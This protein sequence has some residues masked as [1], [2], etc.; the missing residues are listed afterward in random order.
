MSSDVGYKYTTDF[1]GLNSI[2]YVEL[3]LILRNPKMKVWRIIYMQK[4][5][6]LLTFF[7]AF[8]S[9]S[10]F[11]KADDKGLPSKWEGIWKGMTTLTWSSGK[12]E[13][14]ET[15]IQ[16]AAI[17]KSKAKQ[18]KIIYKFSDRTEERNYE[19]KPV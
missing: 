17:S 13:P 8:T 3:R 1:I 5:F 19:L 2:S 18:W 15:Q 10:L 9:L 11:A 16:I 6:I 12:I 4:S 7:L 14:A